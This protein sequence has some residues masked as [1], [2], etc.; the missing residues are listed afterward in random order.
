M[1]G[2]YATEVSDAS[3]TLLLDVEH[4]RWSDTLLGLLQID[5]ALL[6]RLHES[7]EVTGVLTREAADALGLKEGVPV[8]GGAGDQ[9]AGAVGNGIVMAGV[10]SATL[11]TSLAR[12]K[13][14]RQKN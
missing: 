6:P 5:K 3:G 8:V 11:G 10:V 7:P 12:R 13:P 9:A 1:T 4:R 2:G 14:R